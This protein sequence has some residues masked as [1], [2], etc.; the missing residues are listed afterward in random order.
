MAIKYLKKAIKTPETDD[1][2]T[3][4]AVQ[5][6]LDDI[7]KRKEESIKELNKKFD[8]YEGDIIV[9]K[10]KIEEATKNRRAMEVLEQFRKTLSVDMVLANESIREAV[11]DGKATIE[12]S[13]KSLAE[14]TEYNSDLKIQLEGAQKELFL[15]KKLVILSEFL[16]NK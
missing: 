14:M 5:K 9:S 7:E 13:K 6:I 8:N 2:K 10:E 16:L 3:R 12:E 11:K 4:S 15:E 1:D